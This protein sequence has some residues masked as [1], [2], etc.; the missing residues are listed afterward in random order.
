MMSKEEKIE[1]CRR[2]IEAI[3]EDVFQNRVIEEL[4]TLGVNQDILNYIK[5]ITPPEISTEQIYVM[6]LLSLQQRFS[7]FSFMK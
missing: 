2:A 7:V 6:L 4:L 5:I 1:E 3:A